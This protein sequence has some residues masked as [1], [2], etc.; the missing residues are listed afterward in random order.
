MAEPSNEATA[1]GLAAVGDLT[2][3]LAEAGFE[4]LPM[5]V[6]PHT[7]ASVIGTHPFLD[8]P[9]PSEEL[10]SYTLP[11]GAPPEGLAEQRAWAEL[12]RIQIET[13]KVALEL[14]MLR[15]REF[16]S[17]VDSGHAR[18]YTFYA[19]IDAE[20]V[21]ACIAELGMWSRREPSAPFTVIFN[22]PGG[23]VHDGLALFDYIR[24]LRRL[25]HHITTVALGRAASMG[26]IL[27]QAGDRRVVGANAF[28]LVHEVSH[29]TGGKVSEMAD[30][31]EFTRRLQGR[32]LDILAERSTL[33]AREIQRRWTRKEWWL[34]ADEA[35]GLGFADEIL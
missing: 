10:M 5:P 30:N 13:E 27:L 28:V 32:L 14:A 21:Q 33:T 22:S 4:T 19:S 6:D 24:Q 18:V 23:S 15:R 8:R 1:Q 16:E 12:R 35:V 29:Q 7:V 9:D 17:L 2:D 34:A 31:V 25:G 20:S 11:L 26:A 3:D